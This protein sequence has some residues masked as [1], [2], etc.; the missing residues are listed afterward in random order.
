MVSGS[1]EHVHDSRA[2]SLLTKLHLQNRVVDGFSRNLSAEHIQFAVRNLEV[3]GRIFVLEQNDLVRF[4]GY[5][6]RQRTDVGLGLANFLIPEIPE[7]AFCR[8]GIGAVS[9]TLCVPS[10][11]ACCFPASTSSFAGFS[12][13][14]GTSFSFTQFKGFR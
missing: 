4:M 14:A 9:N 12:R 11:A 6:T 10:C 7:T 8:T 1:S 2:S 5:R 13:I 3:G